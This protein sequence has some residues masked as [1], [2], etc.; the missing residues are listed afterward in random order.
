MAGEVVLEDGAGRE[1]P[2]Q[3]ERRILQLQLGDAHG[4]L[5][6]QPARVQRQIGEIA[7]LEDLKEA[8]RR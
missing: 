7:A 2:L 1:A 5:D 8:Q 3:R 4:N 6:E